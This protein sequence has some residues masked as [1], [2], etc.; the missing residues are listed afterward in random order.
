MPGTFDIYNRVISSF[1]GAGAGAIGPDQ[2][3]AGGGDVTMLKG[4]R[5]P[6]AAGQQDINV[7]PLNPP[8]TGNPVKFRILDVFVDVTTAN[9]SETLTLRD[10]ILGGGNAMSSAL[11]LAA[12]GRV[13][14]AAPTATTV[15]A[16][17]GNIFLRRNTTV[18]VG[19]VFIQLEYEL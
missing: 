4:I 11:S 7:F 1:N 15:L 2:L 6:F 9:G 8:G 10:A 17:G 19:S 13:R 12:T 18:A 14:E 3:P 5:V 16:Q